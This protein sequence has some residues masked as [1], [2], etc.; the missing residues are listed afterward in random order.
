MKAIFVTAGAV[1]LGVVWSGPGAAWT[2]ANRYGGSTSHS[3]G[4]TSHT[5]A[6]GGSTTHAYGVGA[7]AYQCLWRRHGA[8]GLWRHRAHQRR[9]RRDIWRSRGWRC[10]HT[11][12]PGRDKVYHPPGAVPYGGYPAYHPPVAVSYY[13]GSGCYGCAAGGAVVGVAA[14]A[15]VASASAAAATSSAY[16]AGVAAGAAPVG[17]YVVGANYAVIPSGCA[18]PTMQGTTYYLCGNTWFQPIYGA[19]G[20]YYRVVPTP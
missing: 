7:A 8:L 4:E 5:N 2:S 15:A 19:N 16:N 6:Y 12:S 11:Y 18:T 14:R 9:G 13:S 17:A 10:T 1:L 3:Y 20:I